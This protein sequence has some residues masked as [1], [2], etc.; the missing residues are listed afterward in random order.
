[1]F[2]VFLKNGQTVEVKGDDFTVPTGLNV[3]VITTALTWVAA[4]PL[5]EIFGIVKGDAFVT[6]G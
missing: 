1:M 6:I 3:V 5:A 4:F 2:K